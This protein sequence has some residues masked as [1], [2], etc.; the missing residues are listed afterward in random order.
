MS[1]CWLAPS[2]SLEDARCHLQVVWR[3]RAWASQV[4]F[5]AGHTP[6]NLLL[7]GCPSHAPSITLPNVNAPAAFAT[8]LPALMVERE[9]LIVA[10]ML[11]PAAESTLEYGTL[12]ASLTRWFPPSFRSVAGDGSTRE[13]ALAVEELRVLPP[14]LLDGRPLDILI[15]RL[16][17]PRD[18]PDLLFPALD[19][20]RPLL[21]TLRLHD[22]LARFGELL[23]HPLELR[24]AP[25]LRPRPVGRVD[26]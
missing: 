3:L 4:A 26:E 24:V 17:I 22:L 19:G 10:S 8:A 25:Q 2:A 14:H 21:L 6:F 13:A 23:L 9:S 11:S 15:L 20:L 16:G 5:P 12:T 7:C 1:L 18:L